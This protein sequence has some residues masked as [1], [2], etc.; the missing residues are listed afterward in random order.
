ML[1]D[2]LALSRAHARDSCAQIRC[3]ACS[4]WTRGSQTAAL[5]GELQ[6]GQQSPLGRPKTI[7]AMRILRVESD[8]ER[9]R[10]R[11]TQ[12]SSVLAITAEPQRRK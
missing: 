6:L 10:C 5:G 11:M 2:L 7:T 8:A 1:F 9:T 12:G 4:Y 3:V